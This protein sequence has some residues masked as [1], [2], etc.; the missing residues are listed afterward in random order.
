MALFDA[1]KAVSVSGRDGGR[2]T[3]GR[4]HVP[5]APRDRD[6]TSLE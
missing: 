4:D 6:E 3:G 2:D 5:A 1:L